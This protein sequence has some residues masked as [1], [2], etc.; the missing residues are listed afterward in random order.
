LKLF[1]NKWN[2]SVNTEKT[3][4]MIFDKSGRELKGYSVMYA[5]QSIGQASE[6][7]YLSI[8]FKPSGSFPYA[9][10]QQSKKACKAMFCIQKYLLS[11]NMNIYGHIKLFNACVQPILLY[12]SEVWSLFT[13]IKGN[14]NVELK[15][16]SFILNKVQM[17]YAK[18]MLDVHKSATHIAVLAELGLY[19]LSIAAL[20][21][22]VIYWIHLL[23]SK[24][25]SLIFHAYR[26]N[27]TLNESLCNKLKQLFSIIGFSYILE[28]QGAFSKSKLL[29]SVTKQLESKY[30]EH[31]KTLLFNDDNKSGGNKIRTYR[32]LKTQFHL[33]SYLCADVNKI[34]ISTFVKIRISNSNLN[35]EKGRYLNTPVEDRICKFCNSGVENEFHF[36][37]IVQNFSLV[38]KNVSRISVMLCLHLLIC[39]TLTNLNL[40]LVVMI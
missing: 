1:G 29:F 7:K 3:K 39:L 11:D 32:K 21:S 37:I 9:T 15:Y 33:E 6:Y 10:D 19:P 25:N 8:I 35:I 23:N 16:D 28:N 24:Y 31:W 40:H 22:S 36:T 20:K 38:V 5:Q 34:S 27:L 18:Y 12:C 2:L 30:I 26:E 14:V 4:V 13:L 17:K